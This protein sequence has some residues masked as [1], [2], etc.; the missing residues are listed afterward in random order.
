MKHTLALLTA[1]A[2][3]ALSVAASAGDEPGKLDLRLHL[4]KG[5]TFRCTCTATWASTWWRGTRETADTDVQKTSYGWE[6]LAVDEKGTATIRVTTEWMYIKISANSGEFVVEYDSACGDDQADPP[7]TPWAATVGHSFTM[8]VLP[9]GRV[10]GIEGADA[11]RKAAMDTLPE[12]EAMRAEIAGFVERAF[13]DENLARVME[14]FMDF[15]PDA[16]VAVGDTWTSRKT[17][18]LGPIILE[19]VVRKS[20]YKLTS[21]QDG[22]AAVTCESTV[23]SDPDGKPLRKGDF[24]TMGFKLAGTQTGAFRVDEKTGMITEG[25]L[26]IEVEG[27]L[28]VQEGPD[29]EEETPLPITIETTVKLEVE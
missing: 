19:P 23:E 28:L 9:T 3:L 22:K 17:I 26:C 25:E 13:S 12:D 8:K 5:Q 20:T 21:R 1:F 15:R 14:D 24:A 6:V 2:V 29:A 27:N 4:E 7:L 18:L 10:I 11:L 16:P